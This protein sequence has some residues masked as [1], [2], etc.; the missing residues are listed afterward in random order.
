[1]GGGGGEVNEMYIKVYQYEIIVLKI[2]DLS[3]VASCILNRSSSRDRY[4]IIYVLL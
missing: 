1:V 3:L 4:I 2:I